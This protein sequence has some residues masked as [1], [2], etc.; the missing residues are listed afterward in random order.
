MLGF[1]DFMARLVGS[2]YVILGRCR[3]LLLT[4]S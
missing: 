3:C 1:E 4:I 2:R